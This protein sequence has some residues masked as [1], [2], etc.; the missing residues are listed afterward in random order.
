[1]QNDQLSQRQGYGY[2]T[3]HEIGNKF[4]HSGLPS[5]NEMGFG[6]RF[7]RK[8]VKQNMPHLKRIINQQVFLEESEPYVYDD[9]RNYSAVEAAHQMLA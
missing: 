8:A 5:L 1:M 4:S 9:R 3:Q 6:P 7:D 2:A